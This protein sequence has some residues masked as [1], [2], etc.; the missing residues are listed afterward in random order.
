TGAPARADRGC[1]G[2]RSRRRRPAET[3]LPPFPPSLAGQT[4]DVAVRQPLQ[5][6][7]IV[8]RGHRVHAAETVGKCRPEPEP[9]QRRGGPGPRPRTGY[10]FHPCR[11]E[12]VVEDRSAAVELLFDR[13]PLFC[14]RF[15]LRSR[16]CRS[17]GDAAQLALPPGTSEESGAAFAGDPFDTPAVGL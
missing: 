6:V 8:A 5:P 14:I 12:P 9:R 3:P 13:T 1:R 15:R 10:G 17:S 4:K 11:P 7:R 16:L 2:R